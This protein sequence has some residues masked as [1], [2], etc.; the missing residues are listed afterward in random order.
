MILASGYEAGLGALGHC[1]EKPTLFYGGAH[2][3]ID[4]TL[5]N[6]IHSEMDAIGILPQR[7]SAEL[8]SYIGDGQAW[9]LAKE[10]GGVFVLPAKKGKD[11]TD[12]ADAVYKNIDFI[13]RFGPDYVCV[14]RSDHV[15]KMDYAKILDVHKRNG[16]DATIVSTSPWKTSRYGMLHV[17]EEGKVLGFEV[18]PQR[19]GMNLASMGIYIFN[20]DTL[21]RRLATGNLSAEWGDTLAKNVLSAMLAEGEKVCSYRFEEYWRDLG[22]VESLWESNMDLLRDPPLFTIQEEGKEVFNSSGVQSVRVVKAPKIEQSILTG[23]HDIRGRVEHSI[24][25]D[26]VVVEEGAEIVDSVLMPNVYVGKN[27]KIHKAVVAPN[28]KFMDNVEIGVTDG[29]AAFVCEHIC[30]RGVSAIASW[31][32]VGAETKLR[33]NSNIEKEAFIYGSYFHVLNPERISGV[34]SLPSFEFAT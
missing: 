18:D 22:T 4:F 11:Y 24:L 16:A 20:W 23:L 17:D 2:R 1:L 7:L 14:F 3:I 8:H 34:S 30:A 13:E 29:A 6:C 32:Y 15:C 19:R 26:S 10:D 31:V 5:S 12:T 21:R 9:T 27:T 33:G 25:S 28:T